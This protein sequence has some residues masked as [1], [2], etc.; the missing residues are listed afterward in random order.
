MWKGA[1]TKSVAGTIDRPAPL[2]ELEA[3]IRDLA[4]AHGFN[5]KDGVNPNRPPAAN[6]PELLVQ[7]KP[8]ANAGNVMGQRSSNWTCAWCAARVPKHLGWSHTMPRNFL[9][10]KT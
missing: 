9:L 1:E 2:L 5:V 8:E 3:M 7:F 10:K 6:R 4:I